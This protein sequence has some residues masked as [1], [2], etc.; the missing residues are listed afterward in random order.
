VKCS[1]GRLT[2]K[3]L[4]NIYSGHTRTCGNC[5]ESLREWWNAAVIPAKDQEYPISDGPIHQKY[6][7]KNVIKSGRTR[8]EGTCSL[9]G[10]Q[11][12]PLYKD[13]L[14]GVTLSCGCATYHT[15]SQ[16]EEIADF[17]KDYEVT[18]EYKIGNY[19][20]DIAVLERNL[21]V[22]FHGLKWHSQE[23]RK[24]VDSKKYKL[25][26]RHGFVC[27]VIFEDEWRD[28]KNAVKNIILNRLGSRVGVRIRPS[29]CD[30]REIPSK[31]ADLF[32][33]KYHYIGGTKSSMNM[34]AF[35]NDECIAVMSFKAP[36]RQSDYQYELTRFTT[37]HGF[38]CNGMASKLFKEFRRKHYPTSIVSFSDNRLFSGEMYS[39]IGF[40][41]DGDVRPDYYWVKDKKRYNKSGLR[42]KKDEHGTESQLREAQGYSKI[43]DCGKIRWVWEKE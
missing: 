15:S 42:K 18:K 40:K 35:H 32:H 10:N 8:I 41:K 26:Q 37:K 5:Y 24:T 27:L 2:E 39:K 34:A 23:K 9:C 33:E 17:I 6:D 28:K 12:N 16:S 31:D 43:Y 7:I 20:Y 38:I 30:F 21:L 22:E 13:V 36:N 4:F 19:Y 25:A 11:W 1:C 3:K 29:K 14:R